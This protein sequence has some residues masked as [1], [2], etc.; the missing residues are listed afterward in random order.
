MQKFRDQ[1]DRVGG[2]LLSVGA[3]AMLASTAELNILLSKPLW[4]ARGYAL[5][6]TLGG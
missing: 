1:R 6:V 4:H 5:N 2:N 3:G